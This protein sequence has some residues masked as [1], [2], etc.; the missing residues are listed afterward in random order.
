VRDVIDGQ[1][2][3][4][5]AAVRLVQQTLPPEESLRVVLAPGDPVG[6]YSA[7]VHRVAPPGRATRYLL[8]SAEAGAIPDGAVI[9]IAGKY[10]LVQVRP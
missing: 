7:I 6:K 8:H 9:A 10:T 3:D 4:E 5:V 1:P 2:T